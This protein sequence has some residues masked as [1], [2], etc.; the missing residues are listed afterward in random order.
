MKKY[1]DGSV[2]LYKMIDEAKVFLS[3]C[4]KR[5]KQYVNV[6]TMSYEEMICRLYIECDNLLVRND[7]LQRQVNYAKQNE[8]IAQNAVKTI[9]E[10][11][12]IAKVKIMENYFKEVGKTEEYGK[13]GLNEAKYSQDYIAGYATAI[14]DLNKFLKSGE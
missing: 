9:D 7:D 10:A 5:N 4:F 11:F 12:Q 2:Q 8:A 1:P 14:G 6:E 13:I 3:D